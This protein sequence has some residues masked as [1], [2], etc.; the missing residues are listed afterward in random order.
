[1][2]SYWQKT[3]DLPQFPRA[4]GDLHTEVL[5]IGGGFAGLLTAYLLQQKGVRV[6]V[7]EKGRIFSG[8]SGKTTAKIT[9]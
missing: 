9:V 3:A 1:M 8:V 6:I 5:V 2:E 7:A 4:Q